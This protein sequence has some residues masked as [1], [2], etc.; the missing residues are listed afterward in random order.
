M[1]MSPVFEQM[2]S[3]LRALVPG[4]ARTRS[5]RV[6]IAPGELIDKITIPEIKSEPIP[7][8][9]KLRSVRAELATLS[10]ARDES[11]FDGEVLAGLTAE[12]KA[13]N[14]SL[15]RIQDKIRMCEQAGDF[16]PRF[17]ELARSVYATNDRRAA[18]KRPINERLGTEIIEEK[19]YAAGGRGRY[20]GKDGTRGAME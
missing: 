1:A 14:E 6:E 7:D 15:W 13:I 20:Y 10:E 19:S 2:A 4:R 18:V 5:V 16:A 9:D 12:L 3:E 17:V 8:G 11:I